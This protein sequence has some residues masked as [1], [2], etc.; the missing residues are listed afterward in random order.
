[1]ARRALLVCLLLAGCTSPQAA[2][3][4]VTTSS[5]PATVSA[6]PDVSGEFATLEERFDARLGVFAVDT[7]S[8]ATIEHRADERF[9][10]ASTIKALAAGALLAQTSPADLARAVPIAAADLAP[11][12][13]PVTE[14]RVG[15]SMTLAELCDAA[16]R[17]SDNSALNLLLRELG[18]PAG[19]DA[20]LERVGD[21]V[22]EVVRDEPGL[23]SAVPGDPRDT[24]TPRALA[25]SLRAYALDAAAPEDR[26]QLVDWLRRNT[27]G[28]AL[29]R[30]GVPDDWDVGDKTGTGAYGT[31]NDVAVVIPPGRSPI[32]LA[33]MSSRDEPDAEHDDALIAETTR[34][35]AAGLM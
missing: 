11:A 28:D 34:V 27:T 9:A 16:V 25:G 14:T 31:R 22:T 17:F 13:S 26:E 21:T 2:A 1:M 7:G 15:G 4:S 33:V 30:A 29:I 8:G 10:Y 6:V 3:P 20:A 35:V 5:P 12:Y 19:L 23:N 24:T 32:V 18:G